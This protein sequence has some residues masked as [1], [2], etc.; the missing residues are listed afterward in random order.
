MPRVDSASISSIS[1][2]ST[3]EQNM[4][5]YILPEASTISQFLYFHMNNS[6]PKTPLAANK[7]EIHYNIFDV[8]TRWY[9]H[10]CGFHPI[11]AMLLRSVCLYNVISENLVPT[12]G[13][14]QLACKYVSTIIQQKY[15]CICDKQVIINCLT[16]CWFNPTVFFN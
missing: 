12:Q 6:T 1:P 16:N 5:T 4:I 15:I 9:S 11:K 13:S 7:Y 14:E 2:W 3:E 8:V 10:L